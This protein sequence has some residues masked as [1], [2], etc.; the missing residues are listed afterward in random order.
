M[1]LFLACTCPCHRFPGQ[2]APSRLGKFSLRR[3]V[4]SHGGS[5]L[6]SSPLKNSHLLRS[7]RHALHPELE[8]LLPLPCSRGEGSPSVVYPAVLSVSSSRRKEAQNPAAID[9]QLD[10]PHVGCHYLNGL[11]ASAAIGAR[12]TVNPQK[13]VQPRMNTD[14]QGF[15][16]PMVFPSSR[17]IL[18]SDGISERHCPWRDG[19]GSIRGLLEIRRRSADILG[20]VF[21][22]CPCA[23]T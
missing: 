20:G 7:P 22:G 17:T 9:G 10:S 3:S 5:S 8:K 23:A 21:P 2:K 11:L 19:S 1:T 15:M 14:S 6:V 12:R 16:P 13:A 4:L 18:A